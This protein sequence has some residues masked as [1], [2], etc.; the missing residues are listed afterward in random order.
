MKKMVLGIA[1]TLLSIGF[2]GCSD[3]SNNDHSD[4][5]FS[6]SVKENHS[7][8]YSTDESSSI[9]DET[10]IDKQAKNKTDITLNA[11]KKGYSSIANVTYSETDKTFHLAPIDG[12][13]ETVTLQKIADAPTSVAHQ[14]ALKNMASQLIEM[15]NMI[16]ENVGTGFKISFDNPY[17][18][19]KPLFIIEDGNVEY[20]ILPQD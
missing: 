15:S 4:S 1:F 7:T 20:P 14:D 17:Q 8:D 2:V 12:L 13:S 18:D 11:L 19:R 6:G 10:S 16:S 5:S 9:S 3:N